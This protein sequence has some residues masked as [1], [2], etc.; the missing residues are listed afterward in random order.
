MV[1]KKL[2]EGIHA[3]LFKAILWGGEEVDTVTALKWKRYKMMKE[4]GWT[5]EQ[6]NRQPASLITEIWALMQTESKA[7]N[8]AMREANG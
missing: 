6:Y 8:K 1:F 3:G 5:L 2:I 7:R 4:M